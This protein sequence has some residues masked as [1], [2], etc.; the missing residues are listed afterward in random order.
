[1]PGWFFVLQQQ[2]SEPRF[3]LDSD[4]F[5]PGESGEVPALDTWN[6]LNWGHVARDAAALGALTHLPVTSMALTPSQPVKGVWGR[7]A[8]HMAHITKQ[9]PVRV[10]IH[11]SEFLP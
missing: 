2:P 3:G 1:M 4:P 11:A 10:A 5:G 8:A 9:L 6:S 7:N